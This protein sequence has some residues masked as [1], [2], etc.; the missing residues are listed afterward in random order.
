[1]IR[2][3]H[4]FFALSSFSN[5]HSF[6]SHLGIFGKKNPFRQPPQWGLKIKYCKQF[7][8]PAAPQFYA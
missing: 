4:Q 6:L 3:P 2:H 8:N 7:L 5:A 1:L